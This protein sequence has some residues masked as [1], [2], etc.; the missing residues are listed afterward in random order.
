MSEPI[1]ISPR[2]ANDLRQLLEQSQ[3]ISDRL[4]IYVEAIGAALDVAPG[5]RFDVQT[6][7]FMPPTNPAPT[8]QEESAPPNGE[9]TE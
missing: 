5:W 3:R 7:T 8:V 4:N 9:R 2:A 6:M 1:A